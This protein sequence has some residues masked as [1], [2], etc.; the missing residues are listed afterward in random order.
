MGIEDLVSTDKEM[1]TVGEFSI[2]ESTALID[3]VETDAMV[4]FRTEGERVYCV[5]R[6]QYADFPVITDEVLKKYLD[7]YMTYVRNE[8]KNIR[9]SNVDALLV[10]GVF[11]VLSQVN[12]STMVSTDYAELGN[13]IAAE[14][15]KIGVRRIMRDNQDVL[16][17]KN[18]IVYEEGREEISCR[19]MN[20][21]ACSAG[22]TII[23]QEDYTNSG[24]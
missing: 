22:K 11:R 16:A 17:T 4:L 14:L 18:V 20:D 23:T 9:K 13:C 8:G 6:F 21:N 12:S 19:L 24:Y 3:G 5:L 1:I 2:R 7:Q 15:R 10:G